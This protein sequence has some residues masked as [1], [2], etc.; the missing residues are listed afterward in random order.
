MS[1]TE[2]EAVLDRPFAREAIVL[3]SGGIDSTACIH[4]LKEQGFFVRGLFVD[5]SQAAAHLEEQAVLAISRSLSIVVSS[6]RLEGLQP[7]GA[8]EL[9]GR[10]SLLISAALFD[11]GGRSCV[12][13]TGIH[14]GT[15]Y[16]D[17][18]GPFLNAM[19]MFVSAQ[20]DGRVSLLSPF[21]TWTKRDIFDYAIK[22]RIS[23]D[24]TYS[25]EAGTAPPCGLCSSCR[26][27]E[28][29]RC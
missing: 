8:G 11:S 19:N 25:C 7:S 20:T 13:A 27:R 23:L 21:A 3:F 9:P 29:L 28:G 10:N 5:Y 16:Y 26:D 1:I 15:G 12:I 4:L 2:M 14:S 18:S 6:L 24:S 22:K 17:C